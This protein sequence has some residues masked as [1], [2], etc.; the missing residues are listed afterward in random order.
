M[1]V[2]AVPAVGNTVCQGFNIEIEGFV[3]AE[4]CLDAQPCHEAARPLVKGPVVTDTR[5]KACIEETFGIASAEQA[6]HVE[7]AVHGGR[8]VVES[9]GGPAAASG[10]SPPAADSQA[11]T[12]IRIEVLAGSNLSCRRNQFADTRAVQRIGGT[13]LALEEP[14][15]I[16]TLSVGAHTGTRQ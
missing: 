8:T 13:K 6:A 12:H 4:A 1:V 5:Y 16:R 3:Q 10:P 7:Q 9:L 2:P 14:V 15:V 11:G